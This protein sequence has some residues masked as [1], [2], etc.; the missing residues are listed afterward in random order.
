MKYLVDADMILYGGCAANETEVNWG[1]DYV[2]I[3][4]DMSCVRDYFTKALIQYLDEARELLKQAQVKDIGTSINDMDF[5]LCFSDVMNWR[6]SVLPTYKSN[7]IKRKPV[8]Y[9]AGKQWAMSTYPSKLIKG[10]EADD[11]IGLIADGE[12][13]CIIS[14]DKDMNTLHSYFYNFL[15]ENLTYN[16]QNA[17]DYFWLLQTLVGDTADGYSGVKGVGKVTAKKALGNIGQYDF[18][19]LGRIVWGLYEK[20]G[21]TMEQML[22]QSRVARILRKGEYSDGVI[23]FFDGKTLNL[24][25]V[26]HE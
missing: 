12:S 21:Y 1:N 16:T 18:K 11:V 26:L 19:E 20:A 13:T 8:G 14:G 15:T 2:S 22:Q 4:T 7:R 6:K 24:S 17:A 10:L 25:E 23:H 3:D 5:I 9:G